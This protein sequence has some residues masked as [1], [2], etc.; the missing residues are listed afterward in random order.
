M[1]LEP[2]PD[3]GISVGSMCEQLGVR[4]PP[5]HWSPCFTTSLVHSLQSLPVNSPFS[6]PKSDPSLTL[7]KPTE[8][9]GAACPVQSPYSGTFFNF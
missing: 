3:L 5:L 6:A 8:A 2:S 9:L 4:P 7:S 1:R